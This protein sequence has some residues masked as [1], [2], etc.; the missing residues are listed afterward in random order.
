VCLHPQRHCVFE[1]TPGSVLGYDK[2]SAISHKAD[3]EG[4][5]LRDAAVALGVSADEFD[6]I[7]VPKTMV[8]DRRRDLGLERQH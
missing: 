6:R 4:S 5:S 1:Q 7:V 8:G 3:D 2:A